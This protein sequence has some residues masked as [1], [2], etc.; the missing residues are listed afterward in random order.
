MKSYDNLVFDVGHVLMS[1]RIPAMLS[2]Y[3]LTEEEKERFSRAVFMSPYWM[4]LDYERIPFEELVDKF[5][6]GD[7][8][9]EEAIRWFFAHMEYMHVGRTEIWKRVRKLKEKGYR[10]Y[11][12]SNYSREM[13]RLHTEGADFMQLLDGKVV[14]YE[15][16]EIKPDAAIY[17]ELFRRYSLDPSRCLFFDDR[18]ENVEGSKACGMDAVQVTSEEQL[19]GL[20]DQLLEDE[21]LSL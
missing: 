8:G 15:I 10:I 2:D 3:G 19:A 11:L 13:F 1:Y 5:V 4:E 12:L 6:E 14:S 18:A 7:P 21:S 9:L 20:L 17:E 16:H